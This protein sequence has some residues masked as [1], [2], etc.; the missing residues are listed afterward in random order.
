MP[1][2]NSNYAGDLAA[3]TLDNYSGKLADNITN[4]NAL[5]KQ[6]NKKGNFKVYA[7]G[8]KKILQELEYAEVANV[9]WY[10]GAQQ[11]DVSPNDL[12]GV[13]EFAWKQIVGV[14]TITGLE[15]IINGGSDV[16]IHNL[17]KA[18]MRTLEKSLTNAVSTALYAV[19]TGNDGLEF[20]GLQHIVADTNT[21]TVG[22]ISGTA[23]SWWRN[24]ATNVTWTTTTVQNVLNTAWLTVIRGA[25]KPDIIPAAGTPYQKYWE[26]LTANQRFTDDGQAGAGF[27]S[28]VYQGNVP[29]VYDDQCPSDHLYMLTSDY[30]H[31]RPAPGRW[32]KSLGER[33]SVNQDAIVVPMASAANMTCSNRSL[34]AVLY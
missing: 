6:I 11:F 8:G 7:N 24:T 31:L 23:E 22:N 33:S 13:A 19:G 14:V 17:L 34:Q 18:R 15:E 16:Q 5:L 10:S 20:G 28:L 29:I 30:L 4:H 27:T 26:S 3:T 1:I 21:N 32:M 2:P 9:M 12:Y 25:D